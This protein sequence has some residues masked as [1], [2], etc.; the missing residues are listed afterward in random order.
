MGIQHLP[1]II[2][3]RRG[4]VNTGT[5]DDPFGTKLFLTM[6]RSGNSLGI[7]SGERELE[8]E[9]QRVGPVERWLHG[10]NVAA[11]TRPAQPFGGLRVSVW[12]VL[13]KNE[14]FV[15]SQGKPL[16]ASA[17]PPCVSCSAALR[18]LC[19]STSNSVVGVN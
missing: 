3:L 13:M 12:V 4:A 18:N 8:R 2:G 19:A 11:P 10:Q 15:R 14:V 5:W 17:M 16:V 6:E 9:K 1:Q 7:A